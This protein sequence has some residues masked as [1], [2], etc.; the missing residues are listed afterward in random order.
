MIATC[1]KIA[2]FSKKAVFFQEFLGIDC[3]IY[4]SKDIDMR[5]FEPIQVAKN[6]EREEFKK[7]FDNQTNLLK[8]L[9]VFAVLQYI[10]LMIILQH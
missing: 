4:R 5:K 1:C 2:F 9:L 8:A 10:F 7:I 3:F 6:K